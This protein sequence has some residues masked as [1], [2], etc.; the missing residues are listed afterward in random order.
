MIGDD[1]SDQDG[2][3]Q[4][5]SQHNNT[6][7]NLIG[8]NKSDCDKYEVN[9]LQHEGFSIKHDDRLSPSSMQTI[10]DIDWSLEA[11]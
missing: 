6:L 3:E 1:E 8:F 11:L 2:L 4:N 5:E 7:C 10:E 9:W